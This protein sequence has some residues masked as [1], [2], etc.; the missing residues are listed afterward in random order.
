MSEDNA[1]NNGGQQAGL[2]DGSSYW[3]ING[4]QFA[5]TNMGS[6]HFPLAVAAT[7]PTAI[8]L[9]N[10]QVSPCSLFNSFVFLISRLN[11]CMN[12]AGGYGWWEQSIPIRVL[13]NAIE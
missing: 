9:S 1:Y 4:Y 3:G 12:S 7:T 11:G 13:T 5:A 10:A 8:H 2:G 6:E